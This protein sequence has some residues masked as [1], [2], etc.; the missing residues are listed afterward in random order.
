M[1]AGTQLAWLQ[2][3]KQKG[4]FAVAPAG[5]AFA[6]TLM[7]GQIGLRD[8]LLATG[9]RFYSHLR[10]DIVMTS[11]QYQFEEGA[12][13][14]PQRRF[15]QAAAVE[16][17]ESC[18]PVSIGWLPLPRSL[19]PWRRSRARRARLG[20]GRTTQ[21]RNVQSVGKAAQAAAKKLT[22]ERLER[23]RKAKGKSR[24]V[25]KA[26]EPCGVRA[27][28]IRDRQFAHDSRKCSRRDSGFIVQR[29]PPGASGA[30]AGRAWFPKNNR[31]EHNVK[32]TS[33]CYQDAWIERPPQ[34]PYGRRCPTSRTPDSGKF[35]D[36][37]NV[38]LSPGR[39]DRPVCA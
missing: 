33:G 14:I 23:E 7:L 38:Y 32:Y 5:V 13:F 37:Y 26:S 34:R 25:G 16:G 8:S 18:L 12:A 29:V 22:A 36:L 35:V 6:V 4:H 31:V 19:P 11:W 39:K 9:V 2:L 1:K 15:P 3:V 10:G 28:S 24:R 30:R 17:V 21:R 27:P 20:V